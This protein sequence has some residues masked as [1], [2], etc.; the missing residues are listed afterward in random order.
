AYRIPD[1]RMVNLPSW[2]R[3]ERFDVNAKAPS[4]GASP[5]ELRRMAQSLLAEQFKLATHIESRDDRAFALVKAKS[6]GSLGPQ[7]KK[8]SAE[9]GAYA[10]AQR[11]QPTPQAPAP[12]APGAS[13]QPC[14][15]QPGIGALAS[16][17]MTMPLLALSLSFEVDST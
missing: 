12:P 3:S 7:L 10:A 1:R 13:P 2:A 8:A 11:A 5:D 16:G 15:T 14:A 9:C 4:A 17:A 6:D